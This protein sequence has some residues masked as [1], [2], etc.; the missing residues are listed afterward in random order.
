MHIHPF[1]VLRRINLHCLLAGIFLFAVN[2]CMAA[3]QGKAS[4]QSVASAAPTTIAKRV[5]V[6]SDEQ[7][8]R[9]LA[10]ALEQ[11]TRTEAAETQTIRGPGSFFQHLLQALAQRHDRGESQFK[12]L[13]SGV[14]SFLPDI[15]HVFTRLCPYGTIRGAWQSA[16]WVMFFLALGAVFETV[17]RS[18]FI[19]KY[20]IAVPEPDK[21]SPSLHGMDKLLGAII[22][23]LPRVL[24]LLLFFGSAYFSFMFFIW[25]DSPYV[26]F[27]FL[28]ALI[29]LTTI[30]AT[31][32]VSS[33]FFAPDNETFR[34]FPADTATAVTAHRLITG[35]FG[36]ITVTLLLAVALRRLEAD[37]AT[38]RLLQL[39]S[40]TLLLLMTALA[41]I[42]YRN[43]VRTHILKRSDSLDGIPSWARKQFAA[44]WHVLAITYLA[45]LWF[46]LLNDLADPSY[47]RR[48]A[49]IPS[50]F[51]VP[52]WIAADRFIQWLVTYTLK[53][54]HFEQPASAQETAPNQDHLLQQEKAQLLHQRVKAIAR[55]ILV[56][57]MLVWIASLWDIR[58]PFFSDL[59]L[60]LWDT[61]AIM[62]LALILWQFISTWIEK[63]I[64]ESLP[65]EAEEEEKSDDEWGG[66][67]SRGRA[68]TLLPMVRKFIGTILVVLVTMTVLSSSGIDI[69]P[70]LAGA[71]VV[72]LAIGFGAQKLVADMF[73]GFFYLL[74]DAFRVGEYIEAGEVSGTVE[75]IT[76]RN[77][78]IRHHRGML[79]IVPHSDLGAITNYMR[80]GIIVKFNLDFPYDAPIDK[81]RKIIKK[82]GQKMLEH[83]EYGKDFIRPVKSQGVREIT[84]SVMTIRVKFTA[85]PGT[86][87]VI[88]REAYRLITEA[89]NAQGIHY[90]HRKVIVDLPEFTQEREQ[91]LPPEAQQQLSTAA[92]AAAMR[93]SD[94][95]QD[96]GQQSSKGHVDDL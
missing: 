49:F 41:V 20:F 8:R 44:V 19:T 95:K 14:P 85:Q 67:A 18:L 48:G 27:F 34:L 84:N 25:T 62:A 74:D 24:G 65:E 89:L 87:F 76:L 9:P 38:V 21:G 6:P 91:H 46:L 4:L 2:H 79:Q 73:S 37:I 40:V 66:A 7:V 83:K 96:T 63:K 90:A 28:A 75:T 42:V 53:V 11:S 82:V 51:I 23:I 26:Q 47:T 94:E 17:V 55:S 22:R 35:A 58:I 50:F 12:Q 56:V 39:F 70:L 59:A 45:L 13:W 36:Y 69:A 60:I 3:E 10:A 72:G 61:L 81:I 16:L 71:G 33:L 68:Y 5:S 30:R 52:L 31:A 64:E 77:V 88:R 15:K 80:G 29:A 86:H 57:L 32:I 92:G 78:M 93:A 1:T 43:R 54:L